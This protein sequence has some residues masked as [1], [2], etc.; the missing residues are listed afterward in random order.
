MVGVEDD[1]P[2][3]LRCADQHPEPGGTVDYAFLRALPD[4]ML[5]KTV[6]VEALQ[7]RD[8]GPLFAAARQHGVNFNELAEATGIKSERISRYAKDGYSN[9]LIQTGGVP[10]WPASAQ[11]SCTGRCRTLRGT[12]PGRASSPRSCTTARTDRG[13]RQYGWGRFCAGRRGLRSPD[14]P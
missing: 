12:R 14:R 13:H 10:G 6:V 9:P 11:S 1:L 4:E 2:A 5:R 3:G 8:L 7:R